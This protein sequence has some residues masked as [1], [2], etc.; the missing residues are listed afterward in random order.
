MRETLVKRDLVPGRVP[1]PH[2]GPRP[3]TRVVRLRAAGAQVSIGQSPVSIGRPPIF[4][5]ARKGSHTLAI[6]RNRMRL[7]A[8]RW[9]PV[10]R[11]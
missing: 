2:Q 5:F 4:T 7:G 6:F 8:E 3:G 9:G 10:S 11:A 1:E